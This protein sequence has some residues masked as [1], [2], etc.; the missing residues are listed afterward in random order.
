LCGFEE[1]KG[2]GIC[3]KHVF[4]VVNNFSWVWIFLEGRNILVFWGFSWSK[5]AI[6]EKEILIFRVVKL[7]VK[8]WKKL[9]VF[10]VDELDNQILITKF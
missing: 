4:W 5:E 2:K 1:E 9:L 3:G 7:D 8:G 10:F 6:G